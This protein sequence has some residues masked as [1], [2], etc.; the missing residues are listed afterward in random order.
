MKVKNKKLKVFLILFVVYIIIAISIIAIVLLL[1]SREQK[2]AFKYTQYN[3]EIGDE[4]FKDIYARQISKYLVNK[5]GE[6]L[7]KIMSPEFLKENKLDKSNFN[8]YLTKKAYYTHKA[9]PG[10][11]KTYMNGD[12]KVYSINFAINGLERVVNIVEKEPYDIKVSFGNKTY[13]ENENK[14]FVSNIE[15]IKFE[16]NRIY[17]DNKQVNY[18]IT[19]TNVGNDS[20]EIN[21]VDVTRMQLITNDNYKYKM[22]N[23]VSSA[24]DEPLTK[25]SSVRKNLIFFVPE[26]VQPNIKYLSIADVK[27]NGVE[28]TI[29]V[30]FK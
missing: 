15:N 23:N 14:T 20:V 9:T 30:P 25:G 24:E 6:E 10:E 13:E 29:L 18:D 26:E 8:D 12:K 1:P 11:F 21:F 17:K 28:K 5:Q 7:F 19:I 22:S 3:K 4:R 27:I 2:N 16:V